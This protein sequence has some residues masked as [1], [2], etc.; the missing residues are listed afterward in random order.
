VNAGREISVA[1][2]KAFTGQ[3][4]ALS[5]AGLYF[6]QLKFQS[7]QF[8][9]NKQTFTLLCSKSQLDFCRICHSKL[10]RSSMIIME[11]AKK[12]LL[13]FRK[14]ILSSLLVKV[15]EKQ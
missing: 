12:S 13:N 8:I 2:T 10:K 11:Y 5:L 14:Q 4:V 7:I 1:S 9:L 15:L 3:V 6:S